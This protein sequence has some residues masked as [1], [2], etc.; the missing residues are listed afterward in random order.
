MI[1]SDFDTDIGGN[2]L[3]ETGHFINK[4]TNFVGDAVDVAT[5][6][7]GEFVD[8]AKDV[9]ATVT[10]TIVD[11]AQAVWDSISFWD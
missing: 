8:G 5:G 2:V 10:N 6:A 3:V 9:S 7:A 4:A 11:A 1:N